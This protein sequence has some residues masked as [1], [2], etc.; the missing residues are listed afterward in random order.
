MKEQ[1]LGGVFNEMEIRN[2]TDK[3]FKVMLTKLG[4]GID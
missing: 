4:R 3:E 1:E 2:S